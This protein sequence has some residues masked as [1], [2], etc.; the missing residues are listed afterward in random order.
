MTVF[1]GILAVVF[2]SCLAAALL[3]ARWL[4]RHPSWHPGD[5]VPDVPEDSDLARFR[6]SRERRIAS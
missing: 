2:L 5:D 1:W 4:R 3:L 6:E